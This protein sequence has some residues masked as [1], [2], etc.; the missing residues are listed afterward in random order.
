MCLGLF[1]YTCKPVPGLFRLSVFSESFSS[2]S[3]LGS[4]LALVSGLDFLVCWFCMEPTGLT[5]S[6]VIAERAYWTDVRRCFTR[7]IDERGSL[8]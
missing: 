1:L 8:G 6:V 5:K 4:L 7:V 3:S 2:F